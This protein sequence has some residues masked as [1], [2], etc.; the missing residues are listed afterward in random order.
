M[1]AHYVAISAEVKR[2]LAVYVAKNDIKGRMKAVVDQ[3]ILDF[4]EKN[5]E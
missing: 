5:H 1:K 4:L 3:S 2:K